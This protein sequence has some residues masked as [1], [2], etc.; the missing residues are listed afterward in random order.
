[1]AK[2][3]FTIAEAKARIEKK[4]ANAPLSK[5]AAYYQNDCHIRVRADF[6]ADFCER[7]YITEA[8]KEKM[9]NGYIASLKNKFL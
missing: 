7:G 6:V 2:F 1:M 8:Q 5:A 4:A 3:T 9:M